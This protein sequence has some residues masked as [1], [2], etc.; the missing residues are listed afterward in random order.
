[1]LATGDLDDLRRA[2]FGQLHK[3]TVNLMGQLPCRH[4]NQRLGKRMNPNR[5]EL[6]ENRDRKRSGLASP[7]SSLTEDIVALERM[8]YNAGLNRAGF[9]PT[10]LG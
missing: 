9:A 10:D 4:Q 5:V 7:G 6:L 2:P 1:M 8:R 3:L